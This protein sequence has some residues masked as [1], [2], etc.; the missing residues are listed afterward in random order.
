MFGIK[1]I[2]DMGV[3]AITAI[4]SIF[5]YIWLFIVLQ[6]QQVTTTEAW[7]TFMI[8]FVLVAFAYIADRFKSN[9]VGTE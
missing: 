1:K 5:S 9:Q 8:F 4:F 7:I 3:F 6:D 2:N